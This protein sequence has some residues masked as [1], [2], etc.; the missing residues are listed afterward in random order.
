MRLR[1]RCFARWRSL[2]IFGS[3]LDKFVQ[4]LRDGRGHTLATVSVYLNGVADVVRRLQAHRIHRSSQLTLRDLQAAHRSFLGGNPAARD[5]ARALEMFLRSQGTVPEG[6]APLPSPSESEWERFA[7][8][9]REVRGLS[10]STLRGH[11][12]RLGAFLKVLRFDR[13]PSRLRQLQTR[14]IDVFLRHC[15]RTNG[16]SSL[17]HF[18][19]TL[20][21]FLQWRYSQGLMA[22]P[23]HERIDTPRVYR[24][25]RLPRAIPWEQVQALLASIERSDRGGRRDFALL[26]LAA[27]YGLRS[28]ELIALKLDDLDWQART[29]RVSQTKTRQPLLLPL[30]DEAAS[31]L[32]EY[33][34]NGRPKS[35]HR[36]LFLHTTA[37]RC[38]L[39]ATA[40]REMLARRV[41]RSGLD[42]PDFGAHVLR[43]SFAMRL[44][45]QGVAVKAIGDALGHRDIEST[46]VYL[47]LAVDDLREAA[48]PVPVS[49]PDESALELVCAR[50]LPRM[51]AARP[52]LHLPARFQSWLAPSLQRYVEL[53]RALGRIFLRE[54]SVL[55]QWDD[56]I[57]REHPRAKVV[58]STMLTQWVK[59]L[60]RLSATSSRIYQCNVRAFLLFHARDHAGTFIP[61]RLAFPKPAPTLAPRLISAVEMGRV[62]EVARQLPATAHHSL[63]AETIR[64]GL[65]LLF[66][67][68]LRRGELLRLRLGDIEAAGTLLRIRRTKFYKS[69]LVPLS[70]SVSSEIKAYF[71]QRQ[72]TKMPMAADSFLM[73]SSCSSEVYCAS[74]LAT[75]WR[76]LC[77]SA[78]VLDGHGHPPRLHDLRHSFAVNALHRWYVQGADVHVQLPRLATYLGH[79]NA[80]S[81]HH[82][83]KLTPALRVSASERFHQHFAALFAKGGLAS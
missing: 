24:G 8:Y 7:A 26:Y 10:G 72:A 73:W 28:G 45:Q 38:P 1:P 75:F 76:Q 15:A 54:A 4:W 3:Q 55:G 60:G 40:V 67:C 27:A 64:I 33:L 52:L 61:D 53:K 6:A 57:Q 56:F 39:R 30:T 42:L 51:R 80:A 63:R 78:G 36:E 49:R 9:L 12:Q 69:R 59:E 20:R 32:I 62:L 66:C 17:Q 11:R 25:E 21:C 77:A 79:V 48:Q 44:M 58:R 70:A 71:E 83:L 35:A 65:I 22:E 34:R 5:A 2:P 47:R 81:T 16:R 68:G 82:Y 14:D 29:L 13:K 18:V 19:A 46:S 74:Q 50:S 23:L 37:P 41:R 43:H 31:V